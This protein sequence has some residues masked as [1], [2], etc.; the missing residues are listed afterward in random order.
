[1]DA[2]DRRFSLGWASSGNPEPRPVHTY[3]I[4]NGNGP[5]IPESVADK[6]EL[7]DLDTWWAFTA[8]R[9]L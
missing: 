9:G 6:G 4:D 3:V 1:M 5:E 8:G 2:D 7:D